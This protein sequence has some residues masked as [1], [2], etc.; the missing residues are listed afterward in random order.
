MWLRGFDDDVRAHLVAEYKEAGIDVRMNANIA[1][2]DKVAGGLKATLEDGSTLEADVIMFATGPP[3]PALS[4]T[5]L[6]L[7]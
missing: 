7:Q 1:S 3:P 6:L 2:I 4:L 5:H